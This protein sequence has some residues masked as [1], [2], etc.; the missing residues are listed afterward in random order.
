MTF[1]TGADLRARLLGGGSAAE[2]PLRPTVIA[3]RTFASQ[4]SV[5]HVR[6][7]A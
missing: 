5:L 4:T 2:S 6:A 1:C 7:H 3:G